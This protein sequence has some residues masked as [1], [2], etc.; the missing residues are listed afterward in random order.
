MLASAPLALSLLALPNMAVSE[1]DA[2]TD[3]KAA[4]HEPAG[5]G[6]RSLMRTCEGE[7]ERDRDNGESDG[8]RARTRVGPAFIQQVA[9]LNT[10]RS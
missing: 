2:D 10:D 6:G 4:R 8:R 9:H 7:R 1:A 5:C 3:A